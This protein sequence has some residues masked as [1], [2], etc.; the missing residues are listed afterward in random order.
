ML[1]LISIVASLVI[2]VLIPIE[3]GKIRNG[4]V[5]KNFAGDRPK[6][7]AAYR[8]QLRML[9]WLGLVFGVLGVALAPLEDNPGERVVKVIAAAIWFVVSVLSFTSLR[10]LDKVADAEAAG[11]RR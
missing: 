4:W 3:V 7:L 9:M 1:E 10:T 5:R 8:K 11:P 6:F 2:C